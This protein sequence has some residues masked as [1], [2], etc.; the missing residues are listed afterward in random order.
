M[1]LSLFSPAVVGCGSP[2]TKPPFGP[3]A[4]STIMAPFAGKWVFDLEKTLAAHKVV[5]EG[6]PSAKLRK[7]YGHSNLTFAG[8]SAVGEGTISPEYRFFRMHKHGS[9]TC[10]V[11]WLVDDRLKPEAVGKCY[12]RFE[13][14]GDELRM[15]V[16]MREYADLDDPDV[17]VEPPVEGDASD[18]VVEA[19]KL[20]FPDLY[21][22][23]RGA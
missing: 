2:A 5:V 22:F 6:E 16:Y 12:I 7:T 11:A 9:A 18:C 14:T 13:T 8:N 20:R 1:L 15:Q 4:T 21:V 23:R 17:A 10:G 19:E 3:V